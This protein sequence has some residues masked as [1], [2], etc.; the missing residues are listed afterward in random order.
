M[1]VERGLE[2]RCALLVTLGTTDSVA[3][4]QSAPVGSLST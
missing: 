1:G 2:A 4:A 3:R